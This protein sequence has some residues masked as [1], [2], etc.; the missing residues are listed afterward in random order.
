M[1]SIPVFK[2]F[3]QWEREKTTL[4]INNW[5][6]SFKKI[7]LYNLSRSKYLESY[8]IHWVRINLRKLRVYCRSLKKT[9]PIEGKDLENLSLILTPGVR[10]DGNSLYIA[11]THSSH[12]EPN[13]ELSKPHQ[14]LKTIKCTNVWRHMKTLW[15]EGVMIV[16]PSF[17][18]LSFLE[19]IDS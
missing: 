1:L 10:S 2:K 18:W 5:F 3:R 6:H 14:W 11:I 15:L 4:D 12:E 17:A 19:L 16:K 9:L 8:A 7:C 13:S